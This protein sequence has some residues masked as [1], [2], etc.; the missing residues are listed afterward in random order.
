L[1]FK[2][3]PF[4]FFPGSNMDA[5]LNHRLISPL[6]L[7][8]PFWLCS[9]FSGAD[10]ARYF[11]LSQGKYSKGQRHN[12]TLSICYLISAMGKGSL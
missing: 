5:L 7:A 4:E 6:L 12:S 2:A 1:S 3:R 9:D 10:G 8:Y 11:K